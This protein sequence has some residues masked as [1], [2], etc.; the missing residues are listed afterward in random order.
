MGVALFRYRAENRQLLMARRAMSRDDFW[1]IARTEVT[2]F[3][4]VFVF[5]Q[6]VADAVDALLQRFRF[7][8]LGLESVEQR[9]HGTLLSRELILKL[10]EFCADFRATLTAEGTSM[11]CS[12]VRRTRRPLRYSAI[13]THL[14]AASRRA[15]ALCPVDHHPIGST[16]TPRTFPTTA[17][18]DFS[19]WERVA[20]H[21]RLSR[22]ISSCT[23]TRS[24]A[25]A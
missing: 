16:G 12:S 20:D 13:G 4:Q 18:A 9:R 10:G 24:S 14:R 7:R 23:A 19:A 17:A 15:S 11:L 25:L 22:L 6:I 3:P 21:S 2:D 1:L 8:R 5:P